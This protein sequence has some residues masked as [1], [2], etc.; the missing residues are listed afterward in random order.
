[1]YFKSLE[2]VGFKS[3]ADKTKLNFEPGV[4]AIVGPNGCGKSNIADAIRWVLGEQSSKSLRASR[5]EDVIFN[6]TDTKEPINFAE[7]SLI[8]SNDKRILPIDYDEVTISRR[9][10]R[11]G[12][13]EYLL[14]KTP[15]RLK[16]INE[17][18]MGT[19][20]G[21]ESY[22]II[23]QG[24]MDLILSSKPEDR[25][26]VFEEASGITKYKAKKKEALRKLEQTEQNL[27]RIN[28]I[29]TEVKRQITSIERQAR[30]A[31][32]YKVDFDKLKELELK[33]SFFDYRNIKTEEKTFSVEG[34]DLRERE[35]ELNTEINSLAVK[36]SDYRQSLNDINQRVADLKAK[37]ADLSSSFNI[38]AQKA[39][40]N[41]E[42][43]AEAHQSREALSKE[44]VLLREKI[45]VAQVSVQKL[46]ADLA[47]ISTDRDVKQKAVEE[48]ESLQ[49]SLSREIAEIE[50]KAKTGKTQI[51]D[52]LAKETH[53][54]NDL[55]KLGADIQNKK[56][57]HR[58][59]GIEKE[60][61]Q[62]ELDSV[63]Q[64]LAVI[65]KE[66]EEAERKIT[67][68]RSHLEAKEAASQSVIS[69]IRSLES[70]IAEQENRRA[71]LRSKI[72]VL[73]D[74]VKKHEGFKQG[75][76]N[77]LLKT[78]EAGS[79]GFGI[80]GVLADLI[81]VESGYEAIV[82]AFLGDDAQVLI[83][84]TDQD[85]ANAIEYLRQNKLGKASFVS[86]QALAGTGIP[87]GPNGA[88]L[89]SGLS[90][91]KGFVKT[92]AAYASVIEHFFGNAYL[93]DAPEQGLKDLDIPGDTAVVNRSGTV[94]RDNTFSGGSSLD[95]DDSI[96]I[97][98]VDRLEAMKSELAGVEEGIARLI[99][100]REEKDKAAESLKSEIEAL[101]RGL[102]AE[103]VNLANVKSR[104]DA[105]DEIVKKLK[106][107]FSV[108]E[109]ELGE[110]QQAID[111]ASKRGEALNNEL[112][113]IERE[114]S[115][116]QQFLDESHNMLA[117]KRSQKDRAALE[118]VA[119]RTEAQSLD[120]EEGSLKNGLNREKGF[121]FE[122]EDN[123]FSKEG[124]S[125]EYAQKAKS[126]DEEIVSLTAQNE[127]ISRDLKV[128]GEEVSNIEG[129]RS[130][131]VDTLSVDELQLKDRE[132]ALESLR[133]QIRDFDVKKTEIAYKKTSLQERIL[134]AYKIDMENFT[135]E[136]E[137]NI[138]WEPVKA[139]IS[140]LKDKLDKMGPVNLVAIDEHKE[141][142]ERHAFLTRQQE[143]LANA[144]DSLLKAI[145]KINKTTKDLFIET[146]Q[147]IQ[148]EFKNFFRLLFGGGQAELVLIDEQD[149]L[150]S[151]IEIIVRP[152]GKKL[153]NIMLL[154]GG[155][156][157]LTAIAL[158]FSIFKVKP[159]PFCVL[160][161]IDAPLD[162]S[163]VIRFS[164]VL[165]DFLKISQFIII[166]HNKRTIELADVMYGITM[167]ERGVS[168]IVSVKFLDRKKED[169]KE[170]VPKAAEEKE[171]EQVPPAR[172]Q[173]A[174]QVS[175]FA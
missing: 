108:T 156:K 72:E 105:Q 55:I 28:D 2:I 27:L 111:D 114:K 74:M 161:E 126:L 119:L 132:D 120:K 92:D 62:K 154:S 112:N 130:S 141:L 69:D 60:T 118:T 38:N 145:Q 42:R 147:K 75:V 26:Y 40:I 98:R 52:Y 139:Q 103:D 12:D 21:T 129:S 121:V 56:A 87:A 142:E 144:K 162:E 34:G 153:Q 35:K 110:V 58:R 174:G 77:L 48:K 124:L 146:F 33:L 3:F 61:V 172:A 63:A 106:D 128:L 11:S 123:V 107:E 45:A 97:G 155:E 13:T 157:A 8:L 7:V 70:R 36:I 127:T 134:Q 164:N 66:F 94:Y 1:M 43:I 80:R 32:R 169:V 67:E 51:V 41:K 100:E 23:E 158:L 160:D 136:L 15:V 133:N 82:S 113:V 19:G 171:S 59:L 44:I 89:P 151:G 109:L 29:I 49:S 88:S 18:L 116:L 76:K 125:E 14:N 5:M 24:K 102:H 85:A 159:S 104:R 99:A 170:E 54:K 17:L 10:F 137:D 6:G 37:Q 95:N 22:S 64:V 57:R 101:E 96:L 20:I 143:D 135:L 79:P 84:D 25:R 150:E 65:V 165:K 78:S 53:I 83:T 68:A 148:V 81:K 16:D 73:D 90:V 71:G 30:K 152:P 115:D 175:A 91:L 50:E 168:K 47:K 122:L 9:L 140:E 117:E 4:T 46:E 166:T 131:V 149:I 138:D 39:G 173:G 31:E 163:N 167:Q 86:L 93:T